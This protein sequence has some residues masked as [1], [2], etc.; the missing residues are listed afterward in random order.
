M[1]YQDYLNLKNDYILKNR[2]HVLYPINM[3]YDDK[4]HSANHAHNTEYIN[5]TPHLISAINGTIYIRSNNTKI[6]GFIAFDRNNVAPSFR[7]PVFYHALTSYD[8]EPS[9]IHD[10][11]N[12]KPFSYAKMITSDN[13]SSPHFTSK[14][15]DAVAHLVD[16]DKVGDN[17]LYYIGNDVAI[18]DPWFSSYYFKVS[19][20]KIHTYHYPSLFRQSKA[21]DVDNVKSLELHVNVDI[22]LKYLADVEY[23]NVDSYGA[24]CNRISTQD[25]TQATFMC[26]PAN[27]DAY[28]DYGYDCVRLWPLYLRKDS[29]IYDTDMNHHK[30]LD[31]ADKIACS[32]DSVENEHILHRVALP[33][34]INNN[35]SPWY[36][37]DDRYGSVSPYTDKGMPIGTITMG[38]THLHNEH[39]KAIYPNAPFIGLGNEVISFLLPGSGKHP[40]I[41]T[42]D[43]KWISVPYQDHVLG[44]DFPKGDNNRK[45]YCM[46]YPFI[47]DSTAAGNEDK[48]Y[49]D[50]YIAPYN[51]DHMARQYNLG[52]ASTQTS[53]TLRHNRKN[54]LLV[55]KKGI[56][57]WTTADD[58]IY[59]LFNSANMINSIKWGKDAKGRSVMVFENTSLLLKDNANPDQI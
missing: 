41:F 24:D 14:N 46:W 30:V 25:V 21:G 29:S 55:S 26:D 23:N 37:Y 32:P 11:M 33:Y 38:Y 45:K 13:Y 39:S 2:M 18:Y 4:P 47:N 22:M 54:K 42:K 7:M 34:S 31:L 36:V 17:K 6:A 43:I 35:Y 15:R 51:L 48:I 56:L 57:G 50:K 58:G 59:R 9:R 10:I 1:A 52:N 53:E 28:T 5:D 40:K 20:D 44:P 19:G 8:G 12:Y 49:T 27:G 16:S 3:Y